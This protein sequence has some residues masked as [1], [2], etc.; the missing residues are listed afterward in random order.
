VSGCANFPRNQ[1]FQVVFSPIADYIRIMTRGQI[2]LVCTLG[3]LLSGMASASAANSANPYQSIVD[4]N[5][6]A[7]KPPPPPPDPALLNKPPPGKITLTGI[8][9]ILGNKRALLK[10]AVPAKPPQPAKDDSYILAE[11]QRDGTV[12][13]LAIDEKAGSVKVNNAGDIVVLTFEKDGAKPNPAA[14]APA[15]GVIPPPPMAGSIPAPPGVSGGPQGL[16][17]IPTRMRRVP[18]TPGDNAPVNPG[19]GGSVPTASGFNPQAN[20]PVMEH[21]SP[22]M[23]EEMIE[24]N[25]AVYEQHGN[26]MSRVLPPTRLGRQIQ[27]ENRAN[28]MPSP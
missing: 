15:P 6:F 8:T 11:G 28:Q 23:A 2:S 7:L 1:I 19:M 21:V 13:I 22:D 12:E 16:K 5:V 20:Q 17:T 25:R 27:E 26:P 9:T 14:H 24:Q 3:I 10:V 18:E 4:R